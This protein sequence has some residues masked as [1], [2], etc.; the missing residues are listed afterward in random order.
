MAFVVS[1]VVDAVVTGVMGDR[2][3]SRQ[4]RAAARGAEA[5]INSA[6]Q[7]IEQSQANL[8]QTRTDFQP[9]REMG[10]GAVDRMGRAMEG[11]Q[12]AF[13]QS[14]GYNFVR[15]EG[16]RDTENRFS[17]GGG[18]G[19]A[20]RALSEFTTGLA[21]TEYGNWFDRNMRMSGQGLNATSNTATAGQN[22]TNSINNSYFN[23]GQARA[24]AELARG[25]AGA[26]R[27]GAYSDA[28]SGG[29]SNYLYG[30][31]TSG[32]GNSP[33]TDYGWSEEM[34]PPAQPEYDFQGRRIRY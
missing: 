21:S 25:Q 20:M 28:A 18:G 3:A 15:D 17:V 32:G 14:A 16:M 7:Q 19:N 9:W 1:A 22:A 26:T 24:G 10:Q 30:Q 2:A 23:Q 12:S 34:G 11:D 6:D 13:T 33:S 5:Q 29:I 31:Q 8:E 27:Y 4:S